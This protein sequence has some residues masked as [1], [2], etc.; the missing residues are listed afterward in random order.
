MSFSVREVNFF[1]SASIVLY[2][3][4]K[5]NGNAMTGFITVTQGGSEGE[6]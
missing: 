3:M 6:R 1:P 2:T 4:I 5:S